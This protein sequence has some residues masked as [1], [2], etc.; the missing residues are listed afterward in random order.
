MSSST[1]TP[2]RSMP[3]T[4]SSVSAT[5]GRLEGVRGTGGNARRPL[6]PPP[7]N[8]QAAEEAESSKSRSVPSTS[9]SAKGSVADSRPVPGS[10]AS[11]PASGTNN[12]FGLGSGSSSESLNS[13]GKAQRTRTAAGPTHFGSKAS[14]PVASANS[15]LAAALKD[16]ERREQERAGAL[17]KSSSSDALRA[18]TSP[19]SKSPPYSSSARNTDGTTESGP[20]PLPPPKPYPPQLDAWQPPPTPFSFSFE[21]EQPARPPS[22]FVDQS[23]QTPPIS[24]KIRPKDARR[25]SKGSA[26]SSATRKR[27]SAAKEK[28]DVKSKVVTSGSGGNEKVTEDSDDLVVKKLAAIDPDTFPSPGKGDA[29]EAA[30]LDL[31]LN[32]SDSVMS[33]ASNHHLSA[34]VSTAIRRVAISKPENGARMT[35]SSTSGDIGSTQ[36]SAKV[37]SAE[38]KPASNQTRQSPDVPNISLVDPGTARAQ[39]QQEWPDEIDDA[40]AKLRTPLAQGQEIEVPNAISEKYA[41]LQTPSRQTNGASGGAKNTKASRDASL[42]KVQDGLSAA[43][44]PGDRSNTPGL[45]R[46]RGESTNSSTSGVSD[47]SRDHSSSIRSFG[48]G[49]LSSSKPTPIDTARA[50]KGRA[51]GL[52]VLS[53]STV[54]TPSSDSSHASSSPRLGLALLASGPTHHSRKPSSLSPNP[55]YAPLPDVSPR[56]QF[57]TLALPTDGADP[58]GSA[59]GAHTDKTARRPGARPRAMSRTSSVGGLSVVASSWGGLTSAGLDPLSEEWGTSIHDESGGSPS[60][61]SVRPISSSSR[62]HLRRPSNV[63]FSARSQ[64]SSVGPQFANGIAPS[65][66]ALITALLAD[67]ALVDAQ[68]YTNIESLDHVEQLKKELRLLERKA[69]AAK[70][71]LKVEQRMRDATA[72][73][74]RTAGGKRDAFPNGRGKCDVDGNAVVE[75]ESPSTPL[76]RTPREQIGGGVADQLINAQDRVDAVTRE[77]LSV[78]EQMDHLRR[79]LLEHQA[80][81]LACRVKDLEMSLKEQSELLVQTLHE[82]EQAGQLDRDGDKTEELESQL[83]EQASEVIRSKSRSDELQRRLDTSEKALEVLRGQMELVSAAAKDAEM[84]SNQRR[85]AEVARRQTDAALRNELQAAKASVERVERE[86]ETERK[87]AVDRVVE[88][89]AE[90]SALIRRA[91][92]AERSHEEERKRPKGSSVPDAEFEASKKARLESEALAAERQREIEIL[93]AGLDGAQQ[94][95]LDLDASTARNKTLEQ[96]LSRETD[97]R[98]KAEQALAHST[99]KFA[100]A[101]KQR[102][103]LKT[104]ETAVHK[105]LSNL[106]IEVSAERKLMSDRAELFVAF[107]RRLESAERRLR[108]EDERC[109]RLLGKDEGREEMDDFLAQIKGLAS[110]KKAKTAGQDID[111]LITSMSTHISDMADELQRLGS[112]SAGESLDSAAQSGGINSGAVRKLETELQIAEHDLERWKVEAESAKRQL[113]VFQRQSSLSAAGSSFDR[114]SRL[115]SGTSDRARQVQHELEARIALLEKQNRRLEEDLAEARMLNMSASGPASPVKVAGS[116]AEGEQVLHPSLQKVNLELAACRAALAKITPMLSEKVDIAD[117]AGS[118]ARLQLLRAA[119][120]PSSQSSAKSQGSLL[121]RDSTEEGSDVGKGNPEMLVDRIRKLINV[122]RTVVE[123]ATVLEQSRDQLQQDVKRLEAR[124][125]ELMQTRERATNNNSALSRARERKLDSTLA[126][127]Q[128]AMQPAPENLREKIPVASRAALSRSSSSGSVAS[129]AASMMPSLHVM[130]STLSTRGFASRS[131]S[132]PGGPTSAPSVAPAFSPSANAGPNSANAFSSSS[133][134]PRTLT[135]GMDST[136]LVSRVRDLERELRATVVV[137]KTAER[138]PELEKELKNAQAALDE[139]QSRIEEVQEASSRQNIQLLE[140]LNAL[141]DELAQARLSLRKL[142]PISPAADRALPALPPL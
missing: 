7:I 132:A 85:D 89:S 25:T 113:A 91:E 53:S 78:Y 138:V 111:G 119:F 72:K 112:S 26:S 46:L 68:A 94:H 29:S 99:A 136:S 74:Q 47:A 56:S 137:R 82:H 101:E 127:L 128:S 83:E 3:P 2:A 133:A 61:H 15:P 81:V 139:A 11:A 23:T 10:A 39:A 110:N 52:Q 92:I 103:A 54:V 5:S 105:K 95:R 44:A 1:S 126:E 104:S 108:K 69:E 8:V 116:E 124:C 100:E 106:E 125:K 90:V 40:E 60:A 45:S 117:L 13:P 38:A 6:R 107:E 70:H 66:D 35:A 98:N 57:A 4:S 121:S 22:T 97:L 50:A 87:A 114:H 115:S 28:L 34:V 14:P 122:G 93:K 118:N 24:P 27:K 21:G 88:T 62:S 41:R 43:G 17:K 75:P 19:Q 16:R 135:L 48:S 36:S 130:P 141:Q 37:G 67:S 65:K 63:S 109:A 71:K 58:S 42:L 32:R 142:Q 131:P 12:R 86:L 73:L 55:L 30:S 9:N 80:S 76:V 120:E 84:R 134:G 33:T 20:P 129:S 64:R 31:R 140:E 102:A 79:R 49:R 59:S 51:N 18:A 123:R 96:L 77:L